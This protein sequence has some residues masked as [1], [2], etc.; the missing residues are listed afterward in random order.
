MV[1]DGD[2]EAHITTVHERYQAWLKAKQQ[3]FNSWRILALTGLVSIWTMPAYDKGHIAWRIH[4]PGELDG[5]WGTTGNTYPGIQ[6]PGEAPFVICEYGNTSMAWCSPTQAR[7]WTL[8]AWQRQVESDAPG[9]A[10][11]A[12]RRIERGLGDVY[13]DDIVRIA[14]AEYGLDYFIALARQGTHRF[15]ENVNR[16]EEDVAMAAKYSIDARLMIRP[17]GQAEAVKKQLIGENYS[18]PVPGLQ[19]VWQ[20][21]TDHTIW[22]VDYSGHWHTVEPLLAVIDQ[23]RQQLPQTAPVHADTLL[24]TLR[25]LVDWP[26]LTDAHNRAALRVMGQQ[27]NL[28]LG[29]S[30]HP[31][32]LVGEVQFRDGSS[33]QVFEVPAELRAE[34]PLAVAVLADGETTWLITRKPDRTAIQVEGILF[35]P[36][37]HWNRRG[38]TA[39][40]SY[41]ATVYLDDLLALVSRMWDGDWISW[42]EPGTYGCDDAPSYRVTMSSRGLILETGNVPTG[43]YDPALGQVFGSRAESITPTELVEYCRGEALEVSVSPTLVVSTNLS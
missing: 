10:F 12:L 21:S 5:C 15:C 28:E 18:Y 43:G 13:G 23:T 16:A 20:D 35:T 1:P 39:P 11:A 38:Q 24:A 26:Y 27:L 17:T 7:R 14:L 3:A 2:I 29:G 36:F 31:V 40:D 42:Q 30:A 22:A 37:H 41:D 32:R 9:S 6:L 33:F 25:I 8:A 19:D 34:K 4:W